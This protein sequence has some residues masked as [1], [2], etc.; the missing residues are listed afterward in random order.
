MA[1]PTKSTRL[2]RDLRGASTPAD[3]ISGPVV[4]MRRFYETARRSAIG[5]GFPLG[6]TA[7]HH[8]RLPRKKET[9]FRLFTYYSTV[10]K[11]LLTDGWS[12][13]RIGGVLPV[14]RL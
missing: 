7:G 6:P 10:F 12:G 9:F 1:Q 4:S 8:P 13:R 2:H 5:R 11:F 14:F 3:A